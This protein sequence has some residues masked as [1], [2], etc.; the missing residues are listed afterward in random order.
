MPT[1]RPLRSSASQSLLDTG[2]GS[3][4]PRLTKR[5]AS[6]SCGHSR[7]RSSDEGV[8]GGDTPISR[9]HHPCQGGWET[10]CGDR[11]R[12]SFRSRACHGGSDYGHGLEKVRRNERLGFRAIRWGKPVDEARLKA[13]FSCHAAKVKGHDL[14]FGLCAL[15]P[16]KV[17]GAPAKVVTSREPRDTKDNKFSQ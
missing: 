11:C 3:W 12:R 7:K 15:R 1:K 14:V 8:S 6:T 4:S 2:S 13:C 17:E 9:R 10:R 16:L 5:A